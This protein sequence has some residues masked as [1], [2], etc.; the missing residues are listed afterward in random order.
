MRPPRLDFPRSLGSGPPAFS[1]RRTSWGARGPLPSSLAQSVTWL[2]KVTLSF[3][4]AALCV[5]THETRILSH[6]KDNYIKGEC[7]FKP[8]SMTCR[9]VTFVN[10]FFFPYAYSL[11]PCNCSHDLNKLAT[12]RS[13]YTSSS[14]QDQL[15]NG[16]SK[17]G[18]IQQNWRPF[19]MLLSY[20]WY[21][22]RRNIY[23]VPVDPQNTS[24]VLWR[25][26]LSVTGQRHE[27]LTSIRF[28][29]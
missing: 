10:K 22:F 25:H 17:Q 11:I 4:L 7:K 12:Y 16:A 13:F 2:L 6:D 29:Q 24:T 8:G 18:Y 19:F 9:V 1:P 14:F 5:H 3:S 21:E 27:K 20:Y 26:S 28:S 23:K 15:V